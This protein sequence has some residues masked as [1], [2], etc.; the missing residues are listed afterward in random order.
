MENALP[1]VVPHTGDVD[2]NMMLCKNA[3]LD[4]WVVPHTGDV[5]RNSLERALH[6]ADLGRPP[7]GGRG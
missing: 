6:L 2:R 7:H 5:D 4:P 3:G 1:L